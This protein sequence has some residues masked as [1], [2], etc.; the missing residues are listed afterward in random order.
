VRR[1]ID[2]DKLSGV[3]VR[4]A[5]RR[6]RLSWAALLLAALLGAPAPAAAVPAG[7]V[8]APR[9]VITTVHTRIATG[10]ETSAPEP[11]PASHASVPAHSPAAVPDAPV[12][13]DG[14][15]RAPGASRAPPLG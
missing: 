4:A 15:A 13:L 6:T 8:P 7:A 11:A 9:A 14:A 5:V 1:P 3:E 2:A 10:T 12:L